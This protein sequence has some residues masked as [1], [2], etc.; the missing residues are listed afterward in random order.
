MVKLNLRARTYGF[1]QYVN[2]FRLVDFARM[3]RVPLSLLCE[4][5]GVVKDSR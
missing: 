1:G 2:T 3:V 4:S 5:R